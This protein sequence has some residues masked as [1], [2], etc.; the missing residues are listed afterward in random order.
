[1]VSL[2]RGDMIDGL[3]D[4]VQ[5]LHARGSRASIRIV[6][7]AAMLL[8][9]DDETVSIWV[10]APA[11]LLAMKLRAARPGRDTDDIAALLAILQLTT[12]DE[13]EALFEHYYPGELPPDRAYRLME[14]I[15]VAGLPDAPLPPSPPQFGQRRDEP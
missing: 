13:A 5:R 9:Y 10:A 3:R 12:V 4:L 1:M 8:R 11:S 14:R 7:G 15:F 2:T 6:G